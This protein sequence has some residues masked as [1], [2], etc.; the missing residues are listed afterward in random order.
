MNQFF[1]LVKAEL[2]PIEIEL[3]SCDW[4]IYKLSPTFWIRATLPD[5][6]SV[7]P[8]TPP[9]FDFKPKESVGVA[10]IIL[11]IIPDEAVPP[12]KRKGVVR[13]DIVEPKAITVP[14][15]VILELVS[16]ELTIEPAL[17]TEDNIGDAVV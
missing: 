1:T 5:P 12:N 7:K 15:N 9:L 16:L 3:F 6:I 11:T 10:I 17:I 13:V 14:P 4:S 8:R 2:V